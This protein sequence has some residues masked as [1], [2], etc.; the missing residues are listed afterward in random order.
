M[1]WL[2]PNRLFQVELEDFQCDNIT[3]KQWSFEESIISNTKFTKARFSECKFTDGVLFNCYFHKC[4]F[5]R[6]T[7]TSK[8]LVKCNFD[9]CQFVN[10]SIGT[11]IE[12][13]IFES[14]DFDQCSLRSAVMSEVRIG[15][16]KLSTCKWSLE[17]FD[18]VTFAGT[19]FPRGESEF[20][21]ILIDSRRVTWKAVPKFL[22]VKGIGSRTV[23]KILALGGT[24]IK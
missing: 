20:A 3:L 8:E 5:D 6:V 9:H 2:P 1:R 7:F 23:K 16:S 12:Q 14:C 18:G 15:E 21:D 24:R 22:K 19:T 11:N 4:V 10:C 13:S 17:S